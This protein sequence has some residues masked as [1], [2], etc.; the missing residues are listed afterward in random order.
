ML[1]IH[2]MRAKVTRWLPDDVFTIY[3][4]SLIIVFTATWIQRL[5]KGRR[6]VS[7]QSQETKNEHISHPAEHHIGE[8]KNAQLLLGSFS[9]ENDN[10]LCHPSGQ[11]GLADRR[12]LQE[13]QNILSHS[14]VSHAPLSASSG[15]AAPPPQLLLASFKSFQKMFLL[16]YLLLT[17][18]DW[19]Q[20]AY[21]YRLYSFYG[22]SRTENGLLFIAGY[23][24]SLVL[25]TWVGPIADRH[26]RKFTVL[27]YGVLYTA[28]CVTKFFN[29]FHILLLGRVSSGVATSILCSAFESWMVAEHNSR[30]FDPSWIGETFSFM[31]T[32]NGLAAIASGFLAQYAVDMFSGHPVAPF[33]LAGIFLIFG[34]IVVACTWRE[35]YGERATT[36]TS[37][38]KEALRI[39]F[40]NRHVGL[41]GLQQALFEGCMYTFVFMWSPALELAV[42]QQSAVKETPTVHP[43]LMN[44]RT[45]TTTT[46]TASTHTHL[47]PYGIIF[48]C[49]MLASSLGSTLFNIIETADSSDPEVKRLLLSREHSME[50]AAEASIH[51]AAV[52]LKMLSARNSMGCLKSL[53]RPSLP[54]LL[55]TVHIVAAITLTIP[56]FSK[57]SALLMFGFVLFELCVGMYWPLLGVLRT[58]F[59]PEGQR[60][61]IINLF[62]IPL[63]LIV[64]TVLVSQGT[65]PVGSVFSVCAVLLLVAALAAKVMANGYQAAGHKLSHREH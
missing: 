30:G 26:G 43:F 47:L 52:P 16:S 59:L 48:A 51:A 35:N 54:H 25:G 27:L 56:V 31:S 46:A 53:L 60:A 5:R 61:T 18:A 65:M 55:Q 15:A 29:N 49:F 50:V 38:I 8:I 36:S 40:T 41:I 7:P 6:K 23:A 21:V 45:S 34:S 64:C 17:T 14:S 2:T 24:S 44:D 10:S 22:Y 13:K 20:G 42:G 11:S 1:G 62:R 32:L 63:N 57:S 39:I 3:L 58:Q 9:S 12:I 4:L 28:S 37:Q 33:G 19:L